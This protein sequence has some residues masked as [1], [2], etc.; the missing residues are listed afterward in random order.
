[1]SLQPVQKQPNTASASARLSCLLEWPHLDHTVCD[2][3]GR[4]GHHVHHV[5]QGSR[6]NYCETGDRQRG[7]HKRT[8]PGLNAPCIGIS[9]LNRCA[10]DPH[11]NSPLSEL[12]IVRVGCISYGR[13]C[14]IVTFPVA[15]SDRYECGHISLHGDASTSLETRVYPTSHDPEHACRK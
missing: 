9:Y 4:S 3:A 1:M 7:R 8:G 11:Q 10:S 6:F 5:V 2:G 12:G 13:V 14:A 15:V